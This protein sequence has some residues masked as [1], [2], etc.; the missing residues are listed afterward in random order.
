MKVNR[1]PEPQQR[2][3]SQATMRR[4][5]E[6]EP[7]Y[8]DMSNRQKFIRQPGQSSSTIG[9]K[10]IPDTLVYTAPPSSQGILP[11]HIQQKPNT[12]S[13]GKRH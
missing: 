6:S 7:L 8:S 12:G 5:N 3:M 10:R 11:T 13:I 1:S 4:A 9:F 2:T